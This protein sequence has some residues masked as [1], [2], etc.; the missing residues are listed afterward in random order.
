M[1]RQGLIRRLKRTGTEGSH[2]CMKHYLVIGAVV[3]GL[4]GCS[5]VSDQLTGA[6]QPMRL[7]VGVPVAAT[8]EDTTLA[9]ETAAPPP[10]PQ[11]RTAEAFD[12]TAPEQR[13]AASQPSGEGAR[14]LGTTVASLGSAIEP[15]LWVKTPL[16]KTEIQG[17]VSNPATGKSSTVALIPIVGPETAGSR[18]SL[19]ALR[20]IGAS[21]TDLTPV[22]LSTSG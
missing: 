9:P 11:A 18:M 13:A 20:L 22:E 21:L 17:R 2:D 1:P 14:I 7:A 4:L 3:L 5:A 10:P 16:V 12:T 8:V 15:G 19:A 6:N